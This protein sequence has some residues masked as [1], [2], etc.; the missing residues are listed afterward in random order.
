MNAAALSARRRKLDGAL[1]AP[2]ELESHLTE[3]VAKLRTGHLVMGWE[4]AGIHAGGLTDGQL[5]AARE[6]LMQTYRGIAAEGVHLWT[7][8]VHTARPKPIWSP[9]PTGHAFADAVVG[10]Y[11]DSLNVSP[12]YGIRIWVWLVQDIGGPTDKWWQLGLVSVDTAQSRERMF[13]AIRGIE[14]RARQL[15]HGLSAWGPRPFGFFDL[16]G[17]NRGSEILENFAFLAN[18]AEPGPP[19]A[20]FPGDLSRAVLRSRV[21][22]YPET[23]EIRSGASQRFAVGVG[24]REYPA[25]TYPRMFA[26]LRVSELDFVATH[27]FS[28]SARDT[29]RR[30]MR[31]KR[32]QLQAHGDDAFS[33]VAGIVQA[34]DELRSGHL[35]MGTHQGCVMVFSDDAHQLL[36]DVADGVDAVGAP[37]LLAVREDLGLEAQWWG[38]LPGALAHRP[39]ASTVSHRN[40]VD[41]APHYGAPRRED[42]H[43]WDEAVA[44]HPTMEGTAYEFSHHIEDAGNTFVCGMTGS[45]KTSLLA[46]WLC[47]FVQMGVRAMV[48]DKDRGLELTTRA[49]GGSYVVIDEDHATG[50]DPFGFPR[51]PVAEGF[52][53]DLVHAMVGDPWTAADS[54][55]VLAAVRSVWDFEAP[56]LRRLTGLVGALD[57]TD[58]N[59]VA[60][61][62]GPWLEGGRYG[63]VFDTPSAAP[64]DTDRPV[65]GC[66]LTAVMDEPKV[67]TPIVE[68]L[69]QWGRLY[70]GRHRH[71]W[72][73]D[74]FWK[75]LD[76]DYFRVK[77]KDLLK[78]IRKAGGIL[79]GAT[80]SPEDATDSQIASAILGQS[81]T[82][83]F[84][85]NE[86]C[87]EA[88][89]VRRLG[90]TAEEFARLSR[91]Q[92]DSRCFL[93]KQ[94]QTSAVL[95][96]DLGGVPEI[97]L[98]SPSARTMRRFD[99]GS[100]G[101]NPMMWIEELT[102]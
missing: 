43:H 47:R 97:A 56:E 17:G 93:L 25:I 95:G 98:L 29:G 80:Q 7:H 62:L 27:S 18:G 13:R 86:D 22:F 41:F 77:I 84:L 91:W 2:I 100:A 5:E 11:A 73:L 99:E 51:T 24:I 74:E 79:V 23:V 45:G 36:D 88:T 65:V 12:V 67:R 102:R 4:L 26:E 40:F 66:D 14:G 82:K 1:H 75:L 87:T 71:A 85:P 59:G 8:W 50:F 72:V 60:A 94:G 90:L 38:Q 19:V 37:G 49:L 34:L 57:A 89:Y 21:S 64:L 55:A 10:G 31:L 6:G 28:C 76:D 46:F 53:H 44:V 92:K 48:L 42:P 101:R 54:A 32:D 69:M 15:E 9:R 78:T 68:Y 52:V 83:I 35:V 20:L 61:R 58:P 30:K 3:H 70:H 96:F 81:V 39:R 16:G 63:W 33:Q